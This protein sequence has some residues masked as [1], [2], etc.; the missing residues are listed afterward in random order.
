MISDYIS[1]PANLDDMTPREAWDAALFAADAAYE[2][3]RWHEA[4]MES[5]HS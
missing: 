3:Q 4:V 2:D 5:W 1:A